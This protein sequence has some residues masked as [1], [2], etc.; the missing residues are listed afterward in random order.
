ME[1]PLHE[2][3]ADQLWNAELPL[4][5]AMLELMAT[6]VAEPFDEDLYEKCVRKAA[7]Y[8]RKIIEGAI[9]AQYEG[10]VAQAVLSRMYADPRWRTFANLRTARWRA[11]PEGAARMKLTQAAYYQKHF[12]TPEGKAKKQAA[13]ARY[14]AKKKAE[15][16]KPK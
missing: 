5:H 14:R 9:E 2:K 11:S 13:N 7:Y 3:Q 6:L 1:V 15:K 4:R 10:G 12:T 16:E 8:K